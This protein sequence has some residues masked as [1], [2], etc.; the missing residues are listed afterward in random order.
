MLEYSL[1]VIVLFVI[2]LLYFKLANHY[3]ITDK[4]NQRSS[5]TQ[6]TLRGGGVIFYF[7]ALAY[8]VVHPSYYY[9]F[10]GLTFISLISFLDDVV[11]IS[12]TIRIFFHLLSISLLSYQ[13]GLF[14]FSLFIILPAII[15]MIGIINA[16]NFMDGINGITAA[17]SLAILS[18]LLIVNKEVQ[19]VESEFIIYALLSVL[20]FG[21][22]N[23]RQKAKCFAGDVGSVSIAFILIFLLGMLIIKTSNFHYLLFLLV[24]GVDTIW[25]IV[26]RLMRKENIFKAHRTH[27]FQFLA[28]EMGINK[29]WVSFSYSFLQFIIGLLVI[30][31]IN[32]P[33]LIQW[34]WSLTIIILLSGIYLLFKQQIL[35][36][37]VL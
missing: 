34:A 18:L 21:F 6:I 24:Y 33:L 10:I 2:E 5:H 31:Y 8:F 1:L 14:A 22:F 28:N 12:N 26:W 27:L 13:I 17:Y 4:P 7:A 3:N 30:S 37:F 11:T 20:V 16:Y 9:F 15:V 36:K 29:L 23:F 25:T 19:F 35:K 32:K